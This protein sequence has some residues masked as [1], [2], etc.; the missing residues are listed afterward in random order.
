MTGLTSGGS[1]V[2]RPKQ[3]TRAEKQAH[4]RAA[5]LRAAERVYRERGFGDASAVEIARCAGFSTGAL[6]SNF[7]SKEDLLLTVLDEHSVT[8]SERLAAM[9][10]AADS[11]DEAVNCVHDWFAERL[12]DGRH[13]RALEVDLAIAALTKPEMAARHRLRQ[14]TFIGNLAKLLQ[15]QADRFGVSLPLDTHTLGAALNGLG[16]GLSVNSLLDNDIDAVAVFR[17]TFVR[18]LGLTEPSER[19]P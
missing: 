9:V 5:L 8:N 16:D 2:G 10:T 7:A 4:T 18:L 12:A 17:R 1:T 15:Q 11:I 13:W 19:T 3:E 6:Y 14:R